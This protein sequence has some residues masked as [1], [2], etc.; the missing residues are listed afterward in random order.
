MQDQFD[1]ILIEV[2]HL[3]VERDFQ[4]LRKV[5]DSFVKIAG[6]ADIGQRLDDTPFKKRDERMK[7]RQHQSNPDH[8][9]DRVKD[10]QLHGI[11]VW[12]NSHHRADPVNRVAQGRNKDQRDGG[13]HG[14]E[15]QM[16]QG[17]PLAL[18]VCP[19]R[20]NDRGN[21]RADIGPDCQ[22][23][24]VLIADLPSRKC[25]QDQNHCRVAGLH[26]HGRHRAGQ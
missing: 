26:D 8:V 19:K 9:K 12:R 14:V 10:G 22:S 17:Q 7:Q 16:G 25:R 15:Y 23:Q 11:V 18:K 5:I 21:S 20:A 3:F 6:L 24:R 4:C 13:G 2:E 1:R